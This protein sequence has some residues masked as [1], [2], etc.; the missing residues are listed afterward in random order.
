M[1][2]QALLDKKISVESVEML[3]LD[4]CQEMPSPL[5][6]ELENYS[7]D[8][9]AREE[10][11]RHKKAARVFE[12]SWL[13]RTERELYDCVRLLH[14]NLDESMIVSINAHLEVLQDKLKNHHSNLGTLGSKEALEEC[15]Q[16]C[17]MLGLLTEGDQN[18]VKRLTEPLYS[19]EGEAEEQDLFMTPRMPSYVPRLNNLNQYWP[20]S[21]CSLAASPAPDSPLAPTSALSPSQ[22]ALGNANDL[23]ISEEL[24]GACAKKRRK[25][26]PTSQE[27]P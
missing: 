25:D 1:Q 17:R 22:A 7:S 11:Q 26:L 8:K 15:K 9:R 18:L 16:A 6:R 23:A 10:E 3:P 27:R 20:Q 2:K 21:P 24:L 19:E 5:Q 14:G 4:P 13:L 12:G